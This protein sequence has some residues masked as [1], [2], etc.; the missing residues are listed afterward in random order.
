MS[1]STG[2]LKPRHSSHKRESPKLRRGQL[3][4]LYTS[5]SLFTLLACQQQKSS[6]RATTG[7]NNLQL[8]RN[9]LHIVRPEAAG[10]ASDIRRSLA[11]CQLRRT[12][13]APLLPLALVPR[14]SSLI[15][16][17]FT[18]RSS[19]FALPTLHFKFAGPTW[20]LPMFAASSS[21]FT[22]MREERLSEPFTAFQSPSKSLPVPFTGCQ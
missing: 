14:G 22:A 11:V 16:F 3:L 9:K 7:G 4:A 6:R 10:G 1:A 18:L 2:T 8:L 5:L 21:L 15:P 20:L 19:N 13:L 17:Q 12:I